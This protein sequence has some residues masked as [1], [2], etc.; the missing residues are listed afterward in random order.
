MTPTVEQPG[1]AQAAPSAVQ[2]AQTSP[3]AGVQGLPSTSTESAPA[4]PL[5]ALGLVMMGL[6]GALLRRTGAKT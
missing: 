5:A 3:V 1:A 2:G 6:G 4:I